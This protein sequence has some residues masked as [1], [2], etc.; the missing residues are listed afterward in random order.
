MMIFSI[1]SQKV[2]KIPFG[3]WFLLKIGKSIQGALQMLLI[4]Y[5]YGYLNER[6]GY[7]I[8]RQFLPGRI[9]E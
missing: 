7:K 1:K 8:N 5:F 6:K 9:R 3:N 4:F 2:M